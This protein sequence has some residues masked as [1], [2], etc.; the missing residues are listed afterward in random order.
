MGFFLILKQRCFMAQLAMQSIQ[1]FQ[2]SAN[3]GETES[4]QDLLN[5]R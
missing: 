1:K 5:P 2:S 3:L 4:Q